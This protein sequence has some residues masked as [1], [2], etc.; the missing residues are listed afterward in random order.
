MDT[1]TKEKRSLCMSHIRSKD[2]SPEI[3]VRKV[4]YNLGFRYRL[5]VDYLPGKPDIVLNKIK[6]VIFVNGCFWHQHKGCKRSTLPKTN[7]KYWEKKLK[8]NV[9]RQKENIRL[10]NKLGWK[11]FLIWEC[12][13]KDIKFLESKIKGFFYEQN[14]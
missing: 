7:K 2:T 11:V 13:T 4:L 8:K 1:F 12:E 3:K 6:T 5:H 9:E 14:K 10:L